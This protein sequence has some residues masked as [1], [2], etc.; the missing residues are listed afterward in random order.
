MKIRNSIPLLFSKKGF[1]DYSP[2]GS[3]DKEFVDFL[4][5]IKNCDKNIIILGD[6]GLGKT[7]LLYAALKELSSRQIDDKYWE[8]ERAIKFKGREIIE[9]VHNTWDKDLRTT[10]YENAVNRYE[11]SMNMEWLFIDDLGKQ[12]FTESARVE[13]HSILDERYENGKKHFITS[14]L[15][16]DGIVSLIGEAA[17]DRLFYNSVIHIM[18]GTSQ[19][20]KDLPIAF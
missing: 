4:R 10:E 18:E 14:N 2:M 13:M 15:H 16:K 3:Y 1:D 20:T 17:A 5:D 12:Y 7:H 8:S 19:R 9:T 6:A 11:A